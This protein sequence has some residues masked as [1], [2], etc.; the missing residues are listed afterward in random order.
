MN[1]YIMAGLSGKTSPLKYGHDVVAADEHLLGGLRKDRLVDVPQVR[2][3]QVGEE[4]RGG[5][6]R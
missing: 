5:N 1:Q 3:A 2:A 4:H 6:R